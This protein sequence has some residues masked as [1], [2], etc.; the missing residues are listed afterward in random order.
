MPLTSV[1]AEPPAPASEP[2]TGWADWCLRATSTDATTARHTINDW[3]ARF[4][5]SRGEM[6]LSRLLGTDDTNFLQA[7]DELHVHHLLSRS[8]EVRYEEGN[9]APDFSI[10]RSGELQASIE[11]CSLFPTKQFSAEVARNERLTSAINDRVRV[12][13][14]YVAIGRI[15]WVREP[16][17]RA[18]TSWLEQTIA[19]LPAPAPEDNGHARV[20][21]TFSSPEVEIEFSFLPRQTTEPAP[22]AAIV[23]MGPTVFRFPASGPR[24][25]DALTRKA[26]GTYN[27]R[28]KPFAIFVCAREWCE[29]EDFVNAIYGDD[30][31]RSAVDNAGTAH[32]SRR[33]NGL[34]AVSPNNVAG[35]NRRTS[36]VF[37]L[38]R[39]WTPGTAVASTVLRFDNPFAA[40]AFPDGLV[41]PDRRF[42]ARST[43]A[44]V[45]MEWVS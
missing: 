16:R 21:R 24:L 11:V 23:V 31:I 28:G 4:P 32:R 41:V 42:Q 40:M 19:R 6:L 34:F 20:T 15:T 33:R 5:P 10:Y 14:W 43:D 1:F 30:E 13:R 45:V 2:F 18:I 29:T 37:G 8:Y 7:I 12:G 3:F 22:D 17:L 25:R 35:R 26:G 36:C 39:A 38:L 27:H 44:G 9:G